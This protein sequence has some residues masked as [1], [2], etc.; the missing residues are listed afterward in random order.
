M[1]I[2]V[3]PLSL[4]TFIRLGWTIDSSLC[5]MNGISSTMLCF[6]SISTLC[7]ISADRYL[8]VVRPMRYKHVLTPKKA[9]YMLTLVWLGSLS[10]AC[11]PLITNYEF[12]PGT[13]HCSPAWHRSC[14]LYG[15]MTVLALGI[16][17]VTLLSTYGMIYSS[18]RKH[19]KRVSHWKVSTSATSGYW[20]S[21]CVREAEITGHE[22]DSFLT[23]S[24]LDEEQNVTERNFS[25][26]K[27]SV[28]QNDSEK[29][30]ARFRAFGCKEE[31]FKS[32]VP[33]RLRDEKFRSYSAGCQHAGMD[34][35]PLPLLLRMKL[36][37][38]P[39]SCSVSVKLSVS[40]LVPGTVS[41]FFSRR[42]LVGEQL[43]RSLS[44]GNYCTPKDKKSISSEPKSRSTVELNQT[45]DSIREE[46]PSHSISFTVTNA[47]TPAASPDL[48]IP[49]PLSLNRVILPDQ[50]F[51]G[52]HHETSQ[53]SDESRQAWNSKTSSNQLQLSPTPIPIYDK[54]V[55]P[56]NPDRGRKE[57]LPELIPQPKS[58]SRSL[59]FGTLHD[60][61]DKKPTLLKAPTAQKISSPL[62]RLRA[63]SKFKSKLRVS[64]V[65]REYKVAKIGFILVMVFFLSWGPYMMVHNCQPSYK[66]PLWVYRIAMWL[67]YL[68]CVLN[69][70]VYAL[71]SKHIRTAFRNHMRCGKR[72]NARISVRRARRRAATIA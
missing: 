13:N 48:K 62:L 54:P 56:H 67:V 27:E 30:I 32:D 16:P 22:I 42:G 47:S 68:S 20:D 55:T 71:S 33:D 9:L 57:N 1:A 50:R 15:F 11:L 8:A 28:D 51:S 18:V 70:I 52:N 38:R 46:K 37:A 5:K 4:A 61:S 66:T 72:L 23:N 24:A 14:E 29:S 53:C 35:N 19:T 45:T 49:V 40:E 34:E 12:H 6:A 17:L 26:F 7:C 64:V 59:S 21:T 41:P 63:I 60:A 2:F 25:R 58:R 36:A 69:P 31:S 65:P 44:L 3:M 39:R 43:H 10:L